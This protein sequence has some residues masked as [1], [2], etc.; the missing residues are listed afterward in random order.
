MLFLQE[1]LNQ[2]EN[3]RNSRATWSLPRRLYVMKKRSVNENE[4]HTGQNDGY[5][6][7]Q[8]ISK[9]ADPMNEE[10]SLEGD[11]F[12]RMIKRSTYPSFL[13]WEISPK[14]QNIK[15]ENY[16]PVWK[17]L[18]KRDPTKE[19]NAGGDLQDQMN[20]RWLKLGYVT[21]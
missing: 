1:T 13:N 3:I 20:N 5:S 15:K 18:T 14:R 11:K 8:R 9:R 17:R 12:Q 16:N 10:A 6:S 19:S 4:D 21:G 7:W 2:N